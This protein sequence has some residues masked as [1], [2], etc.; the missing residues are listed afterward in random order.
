[1]KINTLEWKGRS[2]VNFEIAYIDSTHMDVHIKMY[3]SWEQKPGS[4]IILFLVLSNKVIDF[5]Q[6]YKIQ[7]PWLV[8]LAQYI[9]LK[10]KSHS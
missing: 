10:L 4:N 3:F 1:M 9:L 6:W 7:L 2:I 8:S 5:Q